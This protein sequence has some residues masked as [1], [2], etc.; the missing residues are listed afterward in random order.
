VYCQDSEISWFDWSQTE[1][2]S[3][4]LQFASNVIAFRRAH[5]VL[6]GMHHPS[7]LDP[8]DCGHPEVSWHGVRAWQPDWAP[9]CR[10]LG[11]MW[12]GHHL[13]VGGSPDY[14]YVVANSHWDAHDIELP[15]VDD[16]WVWHLFADTAKENPGACVLGEEK[17]LPDQF[18][19]TI[20]PRSVVAM[21]AR[22]IA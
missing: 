13:D 2:N 5:P 20:S 22:P 19:Y 14:V 8:T 3:E 1:T 9:S 21:V 12:C 11:V 7:S 18:S 4:L 15:R 17:A 10:V 16:G 6:R